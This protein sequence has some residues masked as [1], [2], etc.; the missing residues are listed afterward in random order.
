MRRLVKWAISKTPFPIAYEIF[1]QSARRLGVTA[2]Q[3]KGSYFGP[4]HDQAAIKSYLRDGYWSKN[5]IG[6]IE[7]FFA[8]KP[9]GVFYD[10]GANIGMTLIPVAR[11]PAI[12]CVGFEPDPEN[13]RLLCANLAASGLPF[14]EVQNKAVADR[15]MQLGFTR[16]A[17]NS[18]D[19][20]LSPTGEIMV[21]CIPLDELPV[22]T[23]PFA[24]KIDTQG[25][26]PMIFE[27]GRAH[28]AAAGLIICEYWPWG[29]RRLGTAPNGIIDF[30]RS[31]PGRGMLARHDQ[32][33]TNL[34]PA[35]DL[36]PEMQRLAGLC[37]EFDDADLVLIRD[38]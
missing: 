6:A 27:G 35:I 15:H 28:L 21:D 32:S 3:A 23:E 24:I 38:Q 8:D 33:I 37:G 11:N 31:F 26:E 19:H 13:F 20:R 25:A 1:Y 29:M 18:G 30:V 36:I 14:V 7:Q 22:P 17:Y 9:A 16:S 10:V 2:Y 34:L 12:R 5:I 4:I